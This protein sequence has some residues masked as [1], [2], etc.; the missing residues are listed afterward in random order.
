MVD[1]RPVPGPGDAHLV[2]TEGFRSKGYCGVYVLEGDPAV[3]VE[4][5]AS[6]TVDRVLEA[7]DVLGID[8][9][10]VGLVA[11]THIHLDHAGA[12][13]HLLEE[14]PEATAV[15]HEDYADYLME[16]EGLLASV[17]EAVGDRFDQYGTCI[18]FGED[19]VRRVSGGEVL[20]AGDRRLE[21]HYTPGHA[22]HHVD[23]L[24]RADGTLYTGDAAGMRVPGN[25]CLEVTTPPPAFDLGTYQETLE[26][27]R[28]LDP[29]RLALTH[30]GVVE[31]PDAHLAAYGDL[32]DEWVEDVLEVWEAHD[33]EEA[34]VDELLDRYDRWGK[35]YHPEDNRAI[36]RMD[37][38]G[39]LK[40][41]DRQG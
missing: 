6:P 34:A 36:R 39:V 14:L 16:P 18:P 8:R 41:H 24:D 4:T 22:P 35:A 3:L 1:V 11:P 7:L 37:A 31:D 38:K 21:V 5:G 9:D 19:R 23:Y 17:E 28:D 30:F 15:L 40:W 12:T 27:Q 2:D 33:D 25:G 29:E 10:E 13:G 26:L 32:L 20:E